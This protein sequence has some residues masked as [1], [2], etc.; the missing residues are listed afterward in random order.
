M[1]AF[2]IP[3]PR[4]WGC[5]VLSAL[6]EVGWIVSLKMMAGVSRTI[7]LAGYL[8]FGLGAAVFLSA[9]MKSIPMATAY[10]VW[11]GVSLIGAMLVDIAAFQQPWSTFRAFCAI[12]IVAG[13]CGLRFAPGR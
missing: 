11:V 8:L 3:N 13:S 2:T 7:P 9:A 6:C 1:N 4:A 12:L 5:L 10:A